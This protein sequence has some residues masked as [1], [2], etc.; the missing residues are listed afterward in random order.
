M[1]FSLFKGRKTNAIEFSSYENILTVLNETKPFYV[2][3]Q[4]WNS[5]RNKYIESKRDIKYFHCTNLQEDESYKILNAEKPHNLTDFEWTTLIETML[6][7]FI[8]LFDYKVKESPKTEYLLDLISI[9]RP[10]NVSELIW[11]KLNKKAC[12]ELFVISNLDK[13]GFNYFSKPSTTIMMGKR[14]KNIDQEM[15][16]DYVTALK[17]KYFIYILY[18]L[19]EIISSRLLGTEKYDLDVLDKVQKQDIEEFIYQLKFGGFSNITSVYNAKA[20]LESSEYDWLNEDERSRLEEIA[21]AYIKLEKDIS[22]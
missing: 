15:W 14:P 6:E 18:D 3:Q 17:S 7:H 10:K 19:S 4:E 20:F 12:E 1:F 9:D 21:N 8:D 11:K 2:N 16:S 22:D 13:Y 5:A